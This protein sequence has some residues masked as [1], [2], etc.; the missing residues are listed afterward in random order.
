M[1]SRKGME[2]AMTWL[3]SKA[4]DKNSLDGINAELVLNVIA[5]L[6]RQNNQKGYVINRMR[7][8]LREE[9]RPMILQGENSS[10]IE[11]WG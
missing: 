5:D 1:P 7:T 4:E 6:Q 3:R 9:A 8:T 11:V 2:Q 10:E